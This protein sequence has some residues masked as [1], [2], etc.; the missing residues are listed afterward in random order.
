[1]S[2]TSWAPAGCVKC[3][4]VLGTS[5]QKPP[6]VWPLFRRQATA[7]MHVAIIE[8]THVCYF[9]NGVQRTLC[10]ASNTKLG[11]FSS[12]GLGAI[13]SPPTMF[14]PDFLGTKPLSQGH[15]KSLA[16]AQALKALG[17]ATGWASGAVN[18]YFPL[19]PVPAADSSWELNNARWT[20]GQCT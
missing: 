15:M 6:Q 11:P 19:P 3:T 14:P 2:C 10:F 9:F 8:D 20:Q 17:G 16:R 18:C 1:M 5:P 7:A 13:K 4:E 12:R